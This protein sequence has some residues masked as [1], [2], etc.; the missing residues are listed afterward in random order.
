[1]T[2]DGCTRAYVGRAVAECAAE[3]LYLNRVGYWLARQAWPSAGYRPAGR[4]R[5]A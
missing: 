4:Q 1:M 5:V 3:I 2:P